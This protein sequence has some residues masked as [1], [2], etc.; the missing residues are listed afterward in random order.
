LLLDGFLSAFMHDFRWIK[1]GFSRLL[2]QSV[3]VA[4]CWGVVSGAEAR[5][6]TPDSI[7]ASAYP[8]VAL[9][10]MPQQGRDVHRLILQGGPFAYD[11]DGT[12]FGNRERQLPMHPRG[13]YREYTVKTPGSRNRGARRIICGGKPT[14]PEACYYTEDHY[15]SFRKIVP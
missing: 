1:S 10:E 4:L 12:V 5:K 11:K 15:G 9:A 7:E 13:F 8:T 2:L 3:V 6:P 14:V